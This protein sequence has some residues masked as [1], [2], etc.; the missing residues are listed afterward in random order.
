ME[1]SDRF[2]KNARVVMVCFKER[3]KA[4][5]D[6]PS[7]VEDFRMTSVVGV[8]LSGR[9]EGVVPYVPLKMSTGVFQKV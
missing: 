2:K 3:P 6:A 5:D 7:S 1:E 9:E 8:G 4:S